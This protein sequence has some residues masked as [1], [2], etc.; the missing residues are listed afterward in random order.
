M[1]M[2]FSF[3]G[4]VINVTSR[5]IALGL[6]ACL[7]AASSSPLRAEDNDADNMAWLAKQRSEHGGYGILIIDAAMKYDGG[8]CEHPVLTLTTTLRDGKPGVARFYGMDR[9]FVAYGGVHRLPGGEYF[10]DQAECRTHGTK[11]FKGGQ[12]RLQLR[13][14]EVLDAGLFNLSFNHDNFWWQTTGKTQRKSEPLPKDTVGWLNSKTPRT[15]AAAVHRPMTLTV[16][17]P[18]AGAAQRNNTARP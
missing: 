9:F 13:E 5:L 7:A 8:T 15:F 10:V 1:S 3:P 17:Q 18:V 12:A 16:G 11:T 2:K 14:G 4:S 6:A